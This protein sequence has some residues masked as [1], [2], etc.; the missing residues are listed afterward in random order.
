VFTFSSTSCSVIVIKSKFRVAYV[1]HSGLQYLFPLAGVIKYH[2]PSG[3]N[4]RNVLSHSSRGTK[5][6]ISVYRP[7][8]LCNLE[9]DPPLPLLRML[10]QPSALLGSWVHPS[11][12]PFS[13]GLLP[14]SLP[15]H[16]HFLINQNIGSL[17]VVLI[18]LHHHLILI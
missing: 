16:G 9:G 8:S 2:R 13:Q 15:S 7:R 14:V 17:G 11:N 3:L 5:S 10:R 6:D 4:T 18:L 12:L 1:Q